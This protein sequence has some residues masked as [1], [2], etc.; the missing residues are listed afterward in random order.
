M[1]ETTRTPIDLEVG[2]VSGQKLCRVPA[3]PPEA[4]VGE[5]V[6]GL[7]AHMSLPENDPTGRPVTYHARLER[8]GRHLHATEVV[9]EALQAG[10]RLVLQPNIDAGGPG[11]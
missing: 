2:D 5:L 8:E 3:A 9:G 6:H 10:D 1:I 7:L 4:T 11:A